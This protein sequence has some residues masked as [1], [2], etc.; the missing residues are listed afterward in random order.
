MFATVKA[1][2][3]ADKTKIQEEQ[4]KKG[5]QLSDGQHSGQKIGQWTVRKKSDT[6]ESSGH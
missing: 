1:P 5:K 6:E 4:L 2:H 3:A